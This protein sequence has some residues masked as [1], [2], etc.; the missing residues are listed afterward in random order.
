MDK[1]RLGGFLLIFSGL[2]AIAY[3]NMQFI[4]LWQICFIIISVLILSAVIEDAVYFRKIKKQDNLKALT[5]NMHLWIMNV[6]LGL[7][8]VL[9]F[10]MQS[11]LQSENASVTLL[12]EMLVIGVLYTRTRS[13][14]IGESYL[15]LKGRY[16]QLNNIK[17]TQKDFVF[18]VIESQN[19]YEY[20]VELN[21]GNKHK[22]IV[23]EFFLEKDKEIMID[24]KLLAN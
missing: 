5:S 3:L 24:K 16:I 17:K 22:F 20:T 12:L 1:K 18:G 21:N 23:N 19:L 11:S 10:S 4:H 9:N 14:Y 7:M 15:L 6:L 2:M 13:T 8:V